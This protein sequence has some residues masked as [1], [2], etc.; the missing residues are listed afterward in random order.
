MKVNMPIT[1]NEVC[2]K[3]GQTLV[4][5]TDLKGAITYVNPDF[6]AVSG[7]SEE[8]LI[9][10]NHNV[11]RHPE[12]PAAA[13][14]DLWATVKQGRP[15]TGMVKNRCKNGDYYWVKAN[16]IPITENG[17]VT[18]YMSVRSKPSE[19]MIREAESLYKNV[20]QGQALQM[21]RGNR[22]SALFANLALKHKLLSFVSII[23]LIFV[24]G[25]WESASNLGGIKS[26]WNKYQSSSVRRVSL[27]QDIKSQFGFGGVIHNFKNYV[28][29]GSSKYVSKTE[30]NFKILFDKIN[31]YKQINDVSDS[32]VKALNAIDQVATEYKN[33]LSKIQELVKSGK[34]A[35]QIDTVVKIND[36][37]ALKG[38]KELETAQLVQS[39]HLSGMIATH[40]TS[41]EMSLL[42]ERCISLVFL[43][44]IMFIFINRIIIK[45]LN[46]LSACFKNINEGQYENEIDILRTDEIGTFMQSVA[47]TQVKMRFDLEDAS[48][49][50]REA[51]RIKNALDVCQTN[52]MVA[53]NEF[54]IIYLNNS[55]NEMFI[56]AE[57]DLKQDLPNMNARK[58]LGMNMDVFH[59]S[60][61]H[62]RGLVQGLREAVSTKIN[63]GGRTFSLAATPVFDVDKNRLGTVIEWSDLTVELKRIDRERAISDTNARMKQALDSVSAN[64]MVADDELNIIYMNQAVTDT[65]RNAEPDIKASLPNFSVDQVIGSNIDIFHKSPAHQRQILENSE[66]EMN[67]RIEVGVRVM[68]LI[69]NSI[70]NE[71]GKRIGIVVEWDDVTEK[72]AR[73]EQ[74]KRIADDNAG[75]RM[76]LDVCNTNVMMADN[77]FNINY[78]NQAV[79]SMMSIAEDD[80]KAV[81]PNFNA[82]TLLGKNMDTFHKN[83]NHQRSM[84]A[85]LRSPYI[86]EI[87]VGLRTFSM[88]ATPIF[89][90]QDERL[91]TVVEWEDRTVEVGIE[92]EMDTLIMSANNGDLSKRLALEGKSGFFKSM[93]EGLNTLM[94]STEVFVGDIGLVFESM[95]QGDLTQTINSEYKGEFE[96]IKQNA[97]NTISKMSEVLT[98]IT[99]ASSNVATSANEIEQG[100]DDLSRRTESQASSLEETA[101]SMEELTA[102]VK[103]TAE[104][105]LQSTNKATEAKGKAEEGGGVVQGAVV[106]MSEILTASNK[107]ND[108]IG[109]IDEIAFQTNLLALNAAVEAARAGEQGRGFA[110]V[111][112]EVRTLSQR[113]A[114]A[115]KEIK[116][117][118]RDSVSKVEQ[119]SELVNKSGQVLKEIVDA[120]DNVAG[121]VSEVSIAAAEQNSGIA[122]INQAVAGMDEMTQQNAALVEESS[123]ASRSMSEETK[124]MND[125]IMFFRMDNN[126]CAQVDDYRDNE[127]SSTKPQLRLAPN[128]DIVNASN[129]DKDEWDAF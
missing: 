124:S 107:I 53:D 30:Q 23:A 3:E 24:L 7:F 57:S 52:V 20:N 44:L 99:T 43:I 21:R 79:N 38:L 95:S 84:L 105:A 122:Q 36:A 12:M 2:L 64:V 114:A 116:N 35:K 126:G 82:S 27:L 71:E 91:G 62:Q 46:Y 59:K 123:A 34:T 41:S 32:E 118:I 120:V 42:V 78:M 109:V 51:T 54:N 101:S 121:M 87:V 104:N 10:Q 45:P 103:Q 50:A 47:V 127:N 13:F 22:L 102:T 94:D 113:S 97:N 5:K 8:E 19:E 81:L 55:V 63:V 125:L 85:E 76:A 75:I 128:V 66:Q 29:R 110:V 25:A 129:V 26:D 65:L 74:D 33:K 15:W 119:G 72:L 58:L 37:P 17:D 56:D 88:V 80:I 68:D 39:E 96:R 117:L 11:V 100:A 112:A 86:G 106:A 9:G 115:A 77:D 73:A 90:E 89:N 61:E 92:K 67:A 6:L 98:S 108:I 83:P 18:E 111:A 14:K 16:V 1:E 49:L 31:Q 93:S 60:P 4:S 28:L 70:L 40:I 69:V 48:R